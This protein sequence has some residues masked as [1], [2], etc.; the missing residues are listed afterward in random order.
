MERHP[1]P[2]LVWPKHCS[3]CGRLYT[4]KQWDVLPL[5]GYQNDAEYIVE[6]KN[7]ACGGTMALEWKRPKKNPTDDRHEDIRQR[8]SRWSTKLKLTPTRLS[9]EKLK[10]KW[11][12]CT[13]DGHI[14]L[15]SDLAEASAEFQDYVIVHELLHLRIKNHGR[16]FMMYMNAYLPGWK[17]VASLGDAEQRHGSTHKKN[18]SIDTIDSI[19]DALH[20][21]NNSYSKRFLKMTLEHEIATNPHFTK[22]DLTREWGEMWPR[23]KA[24]VEAKQL[25]TDV[26][27]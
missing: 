3:K 12:Q 13:D 15:S 27:R 2:Q 7:C 25:E 21:Y 5:L 1:R 24:F 10:N 18:P 17:D 11:G 6:M 26:I 8:V 23:V 9:I 14:T 4:E 20:E 22:K 19:V 16:L